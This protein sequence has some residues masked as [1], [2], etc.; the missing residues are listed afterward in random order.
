MG[1]QIAE[2]IRERW[3]TLTK[4]DRLVARRLLSDFPI[5]GLKTLAELAERAGV[6][7]P[8]VIRCVKKLGFDSYPQFQAA[9]HEE[10][11]AEFDSMNGDET[12]IDSNP[13]LMDLELAY[14]QSIHRTIQLIQKA[15]IE[16]LASAIAEGSSSILCLGGRISQAIAMVFQAQLLRLRPNVELVSSNSVERAERLMDLEKNDVVVI[17]DLAPYEMQANSFAK[18]AV[19]AGATVVCFTDLDQS[20]VTEYAQF[21]V[22]ADNTGV[23]NVPSLSAALCLAEILIN[24]IREKVGS[25]AR[26]R[27]MTMTEMSDHDAG[28]PINIKP[29]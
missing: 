18:L 25:R 17:F 16:R 8:S 6:S 29:A 5:A 11:Q 1:S 23:A 12:S 26:S 15:E 14:T 19:D 21:V 4:S 7:A 20:P 3:P 27:S 13:V 28:V 2:R 9:L 10:I 22:C 24:E